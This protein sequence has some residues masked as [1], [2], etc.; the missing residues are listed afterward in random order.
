[1]GASCLRALTF[2]YRKPAEVRRR[3]SESTSAALLALHEGCHYQKLDPDVSMMQSSEKRHGADV[4]YALNGSSGQR[5][6]AQR[7]VGPRFI[8]IGGVCAKDAAQVRLAEYDRVVHAFSANRA[9]QPL[10]MSVLPR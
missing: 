9:D 3:R 5:I 10:D 4:P 1:M 2:T 7:E 6:L 8:R